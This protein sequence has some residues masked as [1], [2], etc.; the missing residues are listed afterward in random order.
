MTSGSCNSVWI[1]F[2]RHRLRL[3][4]YPPPT[5]SPS[6]SDFYCT[7]LYFSFFLRSRLS[8]LFLCTHPLERF[9]KSRPSPFRE[10]G[11]VPVFRVK[12]FVLFI[13]YIPEKTSI[14]LPICRVGAFGA[15]KKTALVL[16]P[17]DLLSKEASGSVELSS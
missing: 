11:P 9:E 5:F 7:P 12:L 4:S 1:F 15:R 2:R 3:R 14:A 17:L 13:Y 6:T 10:I 16:R 8:Q